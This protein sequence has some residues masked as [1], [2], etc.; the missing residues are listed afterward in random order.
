MTISIS[1]PIHSPRIAPREALG[2]LLD[3]D[4]E[5]VREHRRA[6]RE[7]VPWEA[8]AVADEEE[9]ARRELE[10]ELDVVLL[11]MR[12]RQVQEIE[13]AVHRLDAGAY[14]R[15]VACGGAILDTRLRAR[16]FSVRCRACQETDETRR[17][18]LAVGDVNR[19]PALWPSRRRFL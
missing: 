3:A 5:F 9:R 7:S 6:L 17:A 16:P 15:C 10:V 14:G 12:S 19:S 2:R 8:R 11:E 4:L 1:I 18:A 13:A